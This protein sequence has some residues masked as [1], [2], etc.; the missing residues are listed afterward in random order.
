[1]YYKM[2]KFLV[3]LYIVYNKFIYHKTKVNWVDPLLNKSSNI[4]PGALVW[5]IFCC[6][7]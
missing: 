6:Q 4:E 3:C 1:M 7:A 2:C 5:G